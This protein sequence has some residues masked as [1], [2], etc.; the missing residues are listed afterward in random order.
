MS[1]IPLGFWAASGGG[2]NGPAFDLLETT[3]LTSSASS[4]TF[5]GLDDY[6]DYKHL[7]IRAVARN[8][9]ATTNARDLAIRIN[10]DTGTNYSSH[11]MVGTGSAVT[12]YNTTNRTSIAGREAW[13]DGSNSA[14]IFGA[15]VIDVLDF[16]STSKNTTIRA[17]YGVLAEGQQRVAITSGAFYDTS[18]VTSIQIYLSQNFV[19]GSRFSLYGVK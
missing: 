5:S 7:Q 4:V 14:G 12:A 10:A 1:L 9:F 2:A 13:A 16:S 11:S 8:D 17:F 6:S 15:A 19:S 3:T 18:A